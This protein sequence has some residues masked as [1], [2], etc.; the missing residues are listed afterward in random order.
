VPS[1]SVSIR[2]G[3]AAEDD[4]EGLASSRAV[5]LRKLLRLCLRRP[6]DTLGFAVLVA[7]VVTIVANA[8]FRQHGPDPDMLRIKAPKVIRE[9]TGSVI[10]MPRP[11]P[12][13]AEAQPAALPAARPRAQIITDLQRELQRRGFYDG[14]IDGIQGPKMDAAV[15][16]FSKAAGL[17]SGGE[18]SEALL[19]AIVATPAKITH[20]KPA[21]P[22]PTAAQVSAVQRVLSQFGYGQIKITGA[23]DAS[24]RTAVERFE[25]DHKMPVTGQVSDRLLRE[26]AAVT[27]HPVE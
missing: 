1:R 9:T 8:L 14:T 5:L 4:E 23:L 6:A 10:V 25:R 15:N 27:G 3:A 26:L 13:A 16:E 20:A 21:P 24:T 7:M 2:P 19:Q 11:R 22:A 12:P 17:R 18:P